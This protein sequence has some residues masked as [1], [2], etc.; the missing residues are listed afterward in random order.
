VYK[1]GF[2]S[3]CENTSAAL[4]KELSLGAADAMDPRRLADHLGL[5][6]WK[7]EEIPGI[8]VECIS[9]LRAD[10]DSWSAATVCLETRRAVILNSGRST[11]RMNSDFMHELSHLILAHTGARMDVST[12][13]ILLLSTYDRAQ[14][15]EANWLSGVLLLPRDALFSIRKRRL[16]DDEACEFYGCSQE[17][18]TFRFRVTAVDLQLTR[19]RGFA[20]KRRA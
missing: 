14:E 6:V 20:G 18:L 16:S 12:D 4:R 5:V 3:W 15:E 8:P 11:G 7:L 19:S 2:K 17:M 10:S 1:R 13:G 9:V